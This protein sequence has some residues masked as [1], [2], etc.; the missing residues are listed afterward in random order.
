MY[1]FDRYKKKKKRDIPL[2]DDMQQN[3]IKEKKSDINAEK[4]DINAEKNAWKKVEEIK[5]SEIQWF[6]YSKVNT[7]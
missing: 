4:N 2:S 3:Y 7:F 5:D 6:K 1:I